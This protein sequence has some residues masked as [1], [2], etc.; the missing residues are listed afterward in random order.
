MQF[1]N[2]KEGGIFRKTDRVSRNSG[3]NFPE[4]WSPKVFFFPGF[5]KQQ[6]Q[7][8]VFEVVGNIVYNSEKFWPIKSILKLKLK[9]FLILAKIKNQPK[10]RH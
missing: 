2:K 4:L 10:L 9:L 7:T 3:Q 5:G 8:P 6:F 1:P